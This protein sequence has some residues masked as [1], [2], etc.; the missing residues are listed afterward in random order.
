MEKGLL[1][2]LSS[3]QGIRSELILFYKTSNQILVIFLKK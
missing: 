1:E 2:V 3:Y